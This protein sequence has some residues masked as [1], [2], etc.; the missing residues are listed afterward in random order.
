MGIHEAPT[1]QHWN[2]FLALEGDVVRMSRY[3]ELT[4][5][6]FES[7]SLELMR[8]LSGAAS[9]VDVVS[10]R[11]CQKSNDK[12]KADNITKYKKERGIIFRC[13]NRRKAA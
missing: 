11:L 12:S 9:E 2:Y 4:T 3:L 1:P 8:I 6:N 10:K 7:Y 13:G 5:D